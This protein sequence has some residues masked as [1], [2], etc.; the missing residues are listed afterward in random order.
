MCFTKE[1]SLILFI[2]SFFIALRTIIL[3]YSVKVRRPSNYLISS[4][5]KSDKSI[6]KFLLLAG[7]ILLG[8]SLIQLL[9]FFLWS[10]IS[11]PS[12]NSEQLSSIGI[13]LVLY[14]QMLIYTYVPIALNNKL[15][16]LSITVFVLVTIIFLIIV[17]FFKTNYGLFDARPKN[18][19]TIS[20]RLNW[21]IYAKFLNTNPIICNLYYIGYM[22]LVA[23]ASYILFSPLFMFIN[24]SI[25]VFVCIFEYYNSFGNG[26][27]TLWCFLGNFISIYYLLAI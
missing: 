6:R 16:Y 5:F 19:C 20:C 22:I 21:D 24:L 26:L 9:E 13:M 4:N 25:F 3:S 11:E 8:I 7:L 1:M 17:D 14:L 15:K 12:S 18:D 27:G 10:G 2:I 23:I